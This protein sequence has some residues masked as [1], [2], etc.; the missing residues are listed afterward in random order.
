[1]KNIVKGIEVIPNNLNIT[2]G[3]FYIKFLIK[4]AH[5]R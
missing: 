2:K 4:I 1:M 3:F 5:K